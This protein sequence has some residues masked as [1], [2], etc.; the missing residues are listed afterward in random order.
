MIVSLQCHLLTSLTSPSIRPTTGNPGLLSPCHQLSGNQNIFRF[1]LILNPELSCETGGND[2]TRY[3]LLC[4]GDAGG[5]LS[6][7]RITTLCPVHSPGSE[8]RFRQNKWWSE[9][10]SLTE[11]GLSWE[12][13]C[14]NLWVRA[15][16]G[17]HLLTVFQTPLWQ[18]WSTLL[19]NRQTLQHTLIFR[20]LLSNS[21]MGGGGC[22]GTI[23]PYPWYWYFYWIWKPSLLIIVSYNS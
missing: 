9:A 19:T 23:H 1:F 3:Q 21:A 12:T 7:F 20:T 8:N 14:R 11:P 10:S 4:A 15:R 6:N 18:S 22:H 2:N 5:C 17:R 16:G 13:T